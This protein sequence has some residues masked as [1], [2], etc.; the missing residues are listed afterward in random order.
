[1]PPVSGTA[2]VSRIAPGAPAYL[3]AGTGGNRTSFVAEGQAGGENTRRGIK[4]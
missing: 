4:N 3:E 2:S 1:M